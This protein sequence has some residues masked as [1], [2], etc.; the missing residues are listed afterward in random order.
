MTHYFGKNETSKFFVPKLDKFSGSGSKE[1][2][3]YRDYNFRLYYEL[4]ARVVVIGI[5]PVTFLIFLNF[6]IFLVLKKFKKFRKENSNGNSSQRNKCSFGDNILFLFLF[7]IYFISFLDLS[8]Y[9]FNFE[10]SI[11]SGS[12]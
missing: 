1:A 3:I 6:K 2:F 9:L 12:I 4:I 10:K 5:V 7:L 8:Q 11:F